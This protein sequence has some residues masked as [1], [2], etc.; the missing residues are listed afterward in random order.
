MPARCG[1][2]ELLALCRGTTMRRYCDAVTRLSC[3]AA[4]RLVVCTATRRPAI[5]GYGL[6]LG[7]WTAALLNPTDF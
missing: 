5:Y 7:R 4:M 3:G 2:T 6:I 1:T